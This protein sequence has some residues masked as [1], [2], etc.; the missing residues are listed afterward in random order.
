MLFQNRALIFEVIPVLVLGTQNV[1]KKC[2]YTN[3]PMCECV[4]IYMKAFLPTVDSAKAKLRRTT[5]WRQKSPN[6]IDASQNSW[7]I[8]RSC[9]S[10]RW[11]GERQFQFLCYWFS[12]KIYPV[13]SLAIP[14]TKEKKKKTSILFYWR[15]SSFMFSRRSNSVTWRFLAHLRT[16]NFLWSL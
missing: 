2:T 1:E 5:L 6:V 10:R 3:W 8:E 9:T 15:F 11:H 7:R 14:I 13:D 12:R 4:Q 16:T